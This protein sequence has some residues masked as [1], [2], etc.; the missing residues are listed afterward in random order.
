ME[1]IK[2]T[3]DEQLE[4]AIAK[5]TYRLKVL[6]HL[7]EIQEMKLELV[8]RVKDQLAIKRQLKKHMRRRDARELQSRMRSRAAV[9]S[10]VLTEYNDLRSKP[11][12]HMSLDQLHHEEGRVRWQ[13]KRA[14]EAGND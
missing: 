3:I 12:Q 11:H 5:A 7:A 13:A 6:N 8:R 2:L 14:T 9:L 10:S 4:H 1:S